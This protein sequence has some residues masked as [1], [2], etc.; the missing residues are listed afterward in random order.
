MSHSY[1]EVS[2]SNIKIMHSYIVKAAHSFLDMSDFYIEMS[3]SNI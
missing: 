3:H 2:Y 1:T